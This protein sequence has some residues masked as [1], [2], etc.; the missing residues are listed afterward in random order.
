MRGA[1][2]AHLGGRPTQ[3]RDQPKLSGNGV[4]VAHSGSLSVRSARR[5]SQPVPQRAGVRRCS[6]V[7]SLGLYSIG[8]KEASASRRSRIARAWSMGIRPIEDAWAAVAF[9]D[10]GSVHADR[11]VVTQAAREMEICASH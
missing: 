4:V 11:T 9:R 1:W 5:N 7:I 2:R 3:S 10:P 6:P 8:S